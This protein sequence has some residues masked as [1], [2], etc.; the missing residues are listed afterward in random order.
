[1]TLAFHMTI[2]TTMTTSI[3]IIDKPRLTLGLGK[4]GNI[5]DMVWFIGER[6]VEGI[7]MKANM[8]MDSPRDMVCLSMPIDAFG[9]SGRTMY[10]SASMNTMLQEIAFIL[11]MTLRSDIDIISVPFETLITVGMSFVQ[12]PRDVVILIV[13][14]LPPLETV[15]TIRR[16]DKY[17]Y[18][19]S[20]DKFLWRQ[21][22]VSSKIYKTYNLEFLLS[23][24]DRP[25]E[26][27]WRAI[28]IPVTH[29]NKARVGYTT[30]SYNISGE[31]I[32]YIC[33]GDHDDNCKATGYGMY[34][35]ISPDRIY[36]G[37]L[38]NGTRTGIGIEYANN[39]MRYEGSWKCGYYHGVGTSYNVDGSIDYSGSWYN[40]DKRPA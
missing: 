4:T 28:N 40:G 37:D 21:Y 38:L 30:L 3:G 35:W 24:C 15:R 36:M 1:M 17:F 29:E 25:C 6:N 8:R 27:Q 23:K 16:L 32:G 19:I 12:L 14:M 10:H 13:S 22:L 20:S 26:W 2:A 9:V 7:F 11:W 18:R 31:V 39:V 34:R 5:M 33:V